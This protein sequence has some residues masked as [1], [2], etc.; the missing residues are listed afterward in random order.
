V[1]WRTSEV[2]GSISNFSFSNISESIYSYRIAW[3]A[4]SKSQTLYKVINSFIALTNTFFCYCILVEIKQ[5]IQIVRNI[6]NIG[7]IYCLY[8]VFVLIGGSRTEI[9]LFTFILTFEVIGVFSEFHVSLALN[10]TFF[11]LC[12]GLIVIAFLFANIRTVIGRIDRMN[13]DKYLSVYFGAPIVNFDYAVNSIPIHK[14][15]FTG[16]NTLKRLYSEM[17][18]LFAIDD[19]IKV[20]NNNYFGFV[21]IDGNSLGNVYT[22]LLAPYMDG[23][24]FG[25]ILYGIINGIAFT[26]IFNKLY[27]KFHNI[28]R[29]SYIEFFWIMVCLYLYPNIFWTTVSEVFVNLLISA[30]TWFKLLVIGIVVP[31]FVSKI[32]EI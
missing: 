2:F 32:T 3:F 15:S 25:I 29:N 13:I 31:R 16:V 11:G 23:G 18:L 4:I 19:A 8:A 10:K 21:N 5:N 28:N 14:S 30:T 22:S 12:L 6:F 9:L 27:Q 7:I 1:F 26:A 24:Y 17:S 20:A